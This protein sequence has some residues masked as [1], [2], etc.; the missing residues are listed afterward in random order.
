MAS[1][2]AVQLISSL[3]PSSIANSPKARR[4]ASAAAAAQAKRVR[5]T[6]RGVPSVRRRMASEYST[7][8]KFSG[9]SSASRSSEQVAASAGN[10]A[11]VS[12][13]KPNRTRQA[14]RKTSIARAARSRSASLTDSCK[15]RPAKA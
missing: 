13:S 12:V 7:P 1:L 4:M 8:P 5:N 15:A 9:I 14:A 10:S 6:G 2:L 11:M 3:M